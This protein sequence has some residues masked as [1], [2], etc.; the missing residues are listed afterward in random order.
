MGSKV[1]W[2]DSFGLF[3]LGL[4]QNKHNRKDLNDLKNRITQEI[5]AIKKETLKNVFLEIEKRLNFCMSVQD[6]TFEQYF[7]ISL[8]IKTWCMG[9]S[10]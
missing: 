7:S 3:P 9:L 4:Y 10:F 5:Q 6:G 2:H 1:A 8:W